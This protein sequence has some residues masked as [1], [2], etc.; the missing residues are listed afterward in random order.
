MQREFL[1]RP[2]KPPDAAQVL[3]IYE[4]GMKSYAATFDYKLPNWQEWEQKF[5]T[6]VGIVVCARQDEQIVL[7]WA[8]VSPAFTRKCY[9]GIGEISIYISP[10]C[11]NLGLGKMLLNA[12]IAEGAH[13]EFWCLQAHIFTHNI[14][15]IKLH[16]AC[17]FR[18]VGVREKMGKMT[19]GQNAGQWLDVSLFEKRIMSQ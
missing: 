2:L 7:G 3:D 5:F 6:P 8:A 14:A 13:A 10:S 15:C 4:K 16:L 12:L 19:F 17:G 18:L 11:H 1:T 9:Q